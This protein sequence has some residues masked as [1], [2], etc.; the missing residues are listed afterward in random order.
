MLQAGIVP[1]IGGTEPGGV[2]AF[3]LTAFVA[4]PPAK[5]DYRVSR[6]KSADGNLRDRLKRLS[7]ERLAD[8]LLHAIDRQGDSLKRIVDD[9]LGKLAELP[10]AMR[11]DEPEPFMVGNSPAMHRVYDQIRKFG[12][13]D[14]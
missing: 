4:P 12:A 14:A 9:A 7:P 5:R 6:L 1:D 3:E 11:S 2:G 13:A 10:G 8:I